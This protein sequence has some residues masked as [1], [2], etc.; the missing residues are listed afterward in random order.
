MNTLV[1]S[2]RT[3]IRSDQ[4]VVDPVLTLKSI[5]SRE[6]SSSDWWIRIVTFILPTLFLA[7][8][9]FQPW[10]DP[11][12]MFLDPLT[13]AEL[14]GDCCHSHYGFV[15]TAGIL[16]WAATAAIGLFVAAVLFL[17][18][19]K[20]QTILFPLFCGLLTGWIGL[21]D[22]FLLHETV[23]PSFGVPQNLVISIY[24][25]LGCSYAALNIRQILRRD[26]WI[27]AM[28]ATALA[29]SIAVDVVFHSLN[30]M[31]V[32]L[33]DSAKFFGIFCWTS[34]HITS[35]VSLLKEQVKGELV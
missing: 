9:V 31:L 22:A 11:K 18:Q 6:T 10:V 30:P 19:A 8:V 20:V 14:S 32:L 4:H 21:D 7:A 16:L 1:Q 34:F 27:L 17:T 3:R 12:W 28:G 23:L 33:E 15:S 5:F 26:F 29:I 25:I 24:L 2:M 13:A 35:F